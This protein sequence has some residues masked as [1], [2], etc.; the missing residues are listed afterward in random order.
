MF[1][2]FV[3]VW[4]VL[5]VAVV[6]FVLGFLWYGPLFG[7]MWMKLS[8][9]SAMH[10]AKSKKEGMVKPAILNFIGTFV[11]VYVFA[12]FI[13]LLDVVSAIQG[14]V[15]GFWIWLA[16]FASTTLLG[17]VLW[18]GKSWNLYV[19]NGLYWLVNLM[20]IGFLIVVWS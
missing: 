4:T 15:L 2:S 19:F 18:E 1:G 7:K 13:S 9:V 20:L 5:L 8:K 16:F 17:G 3:N 12:G 14:A 6:S 11:M 10:V